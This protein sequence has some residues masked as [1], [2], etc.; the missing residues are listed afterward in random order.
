MACDPNHEQEFAVQ[1]QQINQFLQ[2]IK[3]KLAVMSSKDE[4]KKSTV[5]T[6]LAVFYKDAM[7]Q[8]VDQIINLLSN[9]QKGVNLL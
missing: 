1:S 5:A 3:H 6:N 8:I 2:N 4:V 9:K 7:Q